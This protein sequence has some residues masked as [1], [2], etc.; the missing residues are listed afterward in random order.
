[1]PYCTK[2]YVTRWGNAAKHADS[3]MTNLHKDPNW[4]VIEQSQIMEENGLA[5]VFMTYANEHV[6][7][8]I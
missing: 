5:F 4:K 2:A 7:F 3:Y 6:Q 1:M 8:M